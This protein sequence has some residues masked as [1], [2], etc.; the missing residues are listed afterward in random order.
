MSTQTTLPAQVGRHVELEI[1]YESGEIEALSLDIVAD[2]AA[3][4]TRGLLGEST[5]LAKAVSGKTAGSVLPYRVGDALEVRLL[6]VTDTVREDAV[7]L[8]QRRKET[9]AKAVRQSDQTNLIIFA[10]AVNNKWGEYDPGALLDDGGEE[11]PT[12]NE[13]QTE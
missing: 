12:D 2:A 9:E 3:D 7:D 6:A 8:T 10:S 13:D 4:F 5:P 1:R 11:E